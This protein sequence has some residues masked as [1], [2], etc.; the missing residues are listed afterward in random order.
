MVPQSIDFRIKKNFFFVKIFFRSNREN[1]SI[2]LFY[3]LCS[4]FFSFNRYRVQRPLAKCTYVYSSF[5][6]LFFIV[7]FFISLFTIQSFPTSFGSRIAFPRLFLLQPKK[8]KKNIW[9]YIREKSWSSRLWNA[10][11]SNRLGDTHTHIQSKEGS[12]TLRSAMKQILTCLD[13]KNFF[14]FFLFVSFFSCYRLST[15]I[16]H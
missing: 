2:L 4:F 15:Y 16:F 1:V 9:V 13:S 10:S 8:K 5:F 6:F 11:N 12:K 3:I 14:Y 7:F